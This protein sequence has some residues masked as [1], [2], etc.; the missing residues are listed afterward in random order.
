MLRDHADAVESDLSQYHRLDIRDRW[1]FDEHG[2]RCLP[3]RRIGALVKFLPPDSAT[4]VVTGGS[5]W[6]IDN[7][8]GAHIFQALTGEPH[9]GLPV[10][11]AP[12]DPKKSK[13]VAEFKKRAAERQRQIDAGEIT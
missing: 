4:A 10:M 12:V 6:T 7:Y 11:E 9:P 2:R 8:L 3:L 13:R 1:V 5:G